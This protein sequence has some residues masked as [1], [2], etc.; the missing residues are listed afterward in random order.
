MA[1]NGSNVTV[2]EAELNDESHMRDIVMLIDHYAREPHIRGEPLPNEVTQ[3]LGD[4]LRS[5]PTTRVW[6]AYDGDRAA[7]V[8][9]CFVGFSTFM[10]KPLINIHDLAVHADA[11]GKG[12]GTALINQVE[13][14]AREM[15]CCYVTLEVDDGNPRARELYQRCGFHLGD[16]GV[17]AQ[18]FMKKSV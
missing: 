1:G 13:N 6:L 16:E 18:R 4:A 5:H 3:R 10:A 11:R 7:G 9:V 2:I 17:N 14:A 12:A 8:A 15:G